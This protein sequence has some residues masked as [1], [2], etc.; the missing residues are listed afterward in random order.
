[1]IHIKTHKSQIFPMKA[2][3]G[4]AK[5]STLPKLTISPPPVPC[6]F[7]SDQCLKG[8]CWTTL[9]LRN[10][11]VAMYLQSLRTHKTWNF[12]KGE[13]YVSIHLLASTHLLLCRFKYVKLLQ[14][15]SLQ[16]LNTVFQVN[17]LGSFYSFKI[18][19]RDIFNLIYSFQNVFHSCRQFANLLNPIQL[20]VVNSCKY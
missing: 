18:F 12:L 11:I 15:Q 17:I 6:Y 16:V 14:A 1:M 13:P 19:C 9:F 8:D 7:I 5:L 4:V 10:S 2:H 20:I 3:R